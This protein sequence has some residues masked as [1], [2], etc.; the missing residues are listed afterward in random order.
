MCV[1]RQHLKRAVPR[2]LKEEFV[3]LSEGKV[4]TMDE[5]SG[6]GHCL[7]A[8]VLSGIIDMQQGVTNP[9]RQLRN[10][11][12]KQKGKSEVCMFTIG[13]LL[14]MKIY[15]WK[16]GKD[17]DTYHY[18]GQRVSDEE[19]VLCVASGPVS[20]THLKH[21]SCHPSLGQQLQEVSCDCLWQGSC[22]HQSFEKT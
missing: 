18:T 7:F 10:A 6:N 8:C 16:A 17:L 12:E 9:E 14:A 22:R 20:S 2:G 3:A 11:Q 4:F 13:A 5:V 1:Y 21:C 19:I 15:L